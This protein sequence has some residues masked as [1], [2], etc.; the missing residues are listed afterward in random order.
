M[1]ADDKDKQTAT[2]DK[3]VTEMTQE[4]LLAFFGSA[5]QQGGTN[6]LSGYGYPSRIEIGRAHV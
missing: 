1:A 6:Y 2:G 3:K 4:E 5:G